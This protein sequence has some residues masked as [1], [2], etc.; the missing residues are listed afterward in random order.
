MTIKHDEYLNKRLQNI[1]FQ[2]LYLKESIAAYIEDGDYC[3][4]YRALEQVIKART[5][6]KQFAEQIGMHRA[7]LVDILH[8]KTKAP[9]LITISKI[10]DGL[11]FSLSLD[12]K[13]A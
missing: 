3:A 12:L 4:F 10:L 9:T 11:G 5:T 13:S 2:K 8:C 1:D 7:N 6:V